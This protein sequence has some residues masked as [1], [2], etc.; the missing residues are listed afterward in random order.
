M[1]S[2]TIVQYLIFEQ[3]RKISESLIENPTKNEI[4][5]EVELLLSHFGES[6]ETEILLP[7]PTCRKVYKVFAFYLQ[8]QRH[9][10]DNVL[11]KKLIHFLRF[12]K[13]DLRSFSVDV[14]TLKHFT[15][16][17]NFALENF[18]LTLNNSR[19]NGE[20]IV[21]CLEYSHH[22]LRCLV[23]VVGSFINRKKIFQLFCSELLIPCLRTFEFWFSYS[24]SFGVDILNAYSLNRLEIQRLVETCLLSEKNLSDLCTLPIFTAS[25][26]SLGVAKIDH[27]QSKSSIHQPLE[28]MRFTENIFHFINLFL[29][30]DFKNSETTSKW[31]PRIQAI[32]QIWDLFVQRSRMLDSHLDFEEDLSSNSSRKRKVNPQ[33]SSKKHYMQSFHFT[34]LLILRSECHLDRILR[35]SDCKEQLYCRFL[36]FRNRLF[37]CLSESLQ[38]RYLPEHSSYIKYF[39][40]FRQFFDTALRTSSKIG[41]LLFEIEDGNVNRC[42]DLMYSTEIVIPLKMKEVI[43]VLTLEVQCLQALQPLNTSFTTKSLQ[44]V[45]T[46]FY[47]YDLVSLSHTF[48]CESGVFGFNESVHNFNN[49]IFLDSCLDLDKEFLLQYYYF[50]VLN[51]FS[52]LSELYG[53]LRDIPQFLSALCHC[54]HSSVQKEL[55]GRI[56]YM[57]LQ[58]RKIKEKFQVL[59]C[60]LSYNQCQALIDQFLHSDK[61]GDLSYI[62]TVVLG[63]LLEMKLGPKQLPESFGADLSQHYLLVLQLCS[64]SVKK[65][66]S[67][68]PILSLPHGDKRFKF[69]SCTVKIHFISIILRYSSRQFAGSIFICDQNMMDSIQTDLISLLQHLDAVFG[70]N[71][72][73]SSQSNERI[74]FVLAL[75][76]LATE[77]TRFTLNHISKKII[78]FPDEVTIST[79]LLEQANIFLNRFLSEVNLSTFGDRFHLQLLRFCFSAF[80]VWSDLWDCLGF[81]IGD[82]E[83][84]VFSAVNKGLEAFLR[85]I[86]GSENSTAENDINFIYYD[87]SLS[88]ISTLF[89]SSSSESILLRNALVK[90]VN[91]Q[92]HDQI[93]LF[94]VDAS[95]PDLMTT[96]EFVVRF[97]NLFPV[98]LYLLAEEQEFKKFMQLLFDSA[99]T[100]ITVAANNLT[101][102]PM[103]NSI[104]QYL[105][106]CMDFNC[107]SAKIHSSD[108]AVFNFDILDMTQLQL[109]AF[110]RFLLFSVPENYQKESYEVFINK[111][112]FLMFSSKLKDHD[113]KF[114]SEDT[115]QYFRFIQSFIIS[116]FIDACRGSVRLNEQVFLKLIKLFHTTFENILSR[117][118][119]NEDKPH[120]EYFQ[121]VILINNICY[122]QLLDFQQFSLLLPTSG[123][124]LINYLGGICAKIIHFIKILNSRLNLKA[125]CLTNV[126]KRLYVVNRIKFTKSLVSLVNVFIY[127]SRIV[128]PN[129]SP[130]IGFSMLYGMLYEYLHFQSVP[131]VCSLVTPVSS[132]LQ[133]RILKSL[134][135]TLSFAR[136]NDFEYCLQDDPE[137]S[138]TANGLS[139]ILW[140]WTEIAFVSIKRNVAN[141]AAVESILWNFEMSFAPTLTEDSLHLHLTLVLVYSNLLQRGYHLILPFLSSHNGVKTGVSLKSTDLHAMSSVFRVLF[142]KYFSCLTKLLQPSFEKEK[143]SSE[144]IFCLCFA[145][146][147]LEKIFQIVTKSISFQHSEAIHAK[148]LGVSIDILKNC[149]HRALETLYRCS[150]AFEVA[151][152][153]ILTTTCH[154]SS[155]KTGF[156]RLLKQF[157]MLLNFGRRSLIPDILSKYFMITQILLK[158]ISI[159]GIFH[160]ISVDT[161]T[162]HFEL[163]NRCLGV[164][165]NLD[166][167]EKHLFLL[168]TCILRE[169]SKQHIPWN[170][171]LPGLLPIFSKLSEK[172]RTRA[173][174]LSSEYER[175]I[176]TELGKENHRISNTEV[177]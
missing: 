142:E 51:Y 43:C 150:D 151:S 165:S 128:F 127:N 171:L 25:T 31:I 108:S 21:S 83:K 81:N 82:M 89:R 94:K 149:S 118:T 85:A 62:E 96:C 56:I 135:Q 160:K 157:L 116:V 17:V 64:R 10:F 161:G 58:N 78:R 175:G 156:Q 110:T 50:V 174:Q 170:M 54:I 158:F 106:E 176:L 117:L 130:S 80:P 32:T 109:A 30:S 153:V 12:V 101:M 42:I 44:S 18:C 136:T 3:I 129:D 154:C 67:E 33:L 93:T 37:S 138:Q 59:F 70:E 72:R 34:I 23:D 169:S 134:Q 121:N 177:N 131:S 55:T 9:T 114:R 92:L 5:T 147:N 27:A 1:R 4:E 79:K 100:F 162:T 57:V 172:Q 77:I 65:L 124:S 53:E 22:L 24:S 39:E 126:F 76:D 63:L 74:F 71:L 90:S 173:Y 40:I 163:F 11:H 19:L 95:A 111:L 159:L 15:D 164:M 75:I 98:Q 120:G 119:E 168:L 20:V 2:P 102:F 166:I 6:S 26:D 68:I 60:S 87:G 35:G 47:L 8:H 123:S 99:L 155:L 61:V 88:D 103:L 13:C 14:N 104:I 97:L 140:A 91:R 69:D 145:S 105:N 36:L 112:F 133:E 144:R 86:P 143:G 139:C 16:L 41:K 122:N 52:R 115:K 167:F 84:I 148:Q 7:P 28:N 146:D 107:S 113:D 66:Q 29:F 152:T 49:N 46:H 45:L 73:S 48:N 137:F 141:L 132:I 125:K 38:S